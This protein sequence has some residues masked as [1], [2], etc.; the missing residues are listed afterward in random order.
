MPKLHGMKTPLLAAA[1]YAIVLSVSPAED[2]VNWEKDVWPFIE[3]SC[4]NCHRAPYTDE[5]TGRVKEPKAELRYDG[6]AFILKGGENNDE[7]PTLTPG[8][9]KKSA[10]LQRT[11]LDP[12]DDDFMPS[13]DKYDALTDDQKKTLERW[14][15]QGADFGGWTGATE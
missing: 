8:D 3:N 11:L 9:P 10:M 2:K 14:I 15:E 12:D 7:E 1:A 5:A 13:S 4:V 6:A